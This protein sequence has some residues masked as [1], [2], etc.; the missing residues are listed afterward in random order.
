MFQLSV[1]GGRS[2]SDEQGQEGE[3]CAEFQHVTTGQWAVT[4]QMG[5]PTPFSIE[6]SDS[7]P[8]PLPI[9]NRCRVDSWAVAWHA[10]VTRAQD[11]ASTNTPSI[12]NRIFSSATPCPGVLSFGPLFSARVVSLPLLPPPSTP[13]YLAATACLTFRVVVSTRV[14][15]CDA[16]SP[17]PRQTTTP[18]PVPVPTTGR[19]R[20]S[21][22]RPPF[23][24]DHIQVLVEGN[25]LLVTLLAPS[26]RSRRTTP[27]QYHC[28]LRGPLCSLPP[29]APTGK[30]RPSTDDLNLFSSSRS[31]FHNHEPHLIASACLI[32]GGSLLGWPQFPHHH[33]YAVVSPLSDS[34]VCPRRPPPRP[35]PCAP[36]DAY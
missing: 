32:K 33:H 12:L 5:P 15:P 16:V 8:Q 27:G 28:Q 7:H 17:W 21:I 3:P 26:P 36:E 19:P 13:S 6:F 30:D 10:V 34:R 22:P 23:R 2:V 31:I 1:T 35:C 14:T 18:A 25:R 29:P 9:A 11:P 4:P 20:L 24:P